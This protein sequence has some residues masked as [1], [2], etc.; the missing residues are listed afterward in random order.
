MGQH[1]FMYLIKNLV[2]EGHTMEGGNDEEEAEAFIRKAAVG[3]ACIC[4]CRMGR[5]TIRWRSRT[6]GPSSRHRRPP[7]VDA[8][9]LW[10]CANTNIPTIMTAEKIADA[11]LAESLTPSSIQV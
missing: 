5:P 2:M 1:S 11:I 9:T 7:S 4:T 10:P 8:S 6:L 3:V